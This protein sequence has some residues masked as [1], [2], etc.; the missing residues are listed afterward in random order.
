MN[1]SKQDHVIHRLSEFVCV[2]LQLQ[3]VFDAEKLS[4]SSRESISKSLGDLKCHL[5]YI[6]LAL[7][8]KRQQ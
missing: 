3:F 7:R 5:V 2:R 6:N 4:V 8:L 1:F